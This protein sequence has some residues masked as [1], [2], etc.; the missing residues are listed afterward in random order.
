MKYVL[1]KAHDSHFTNNFVKHSTKTIISHNDLTSK[2]LKI[3]FSFEILQSFL[4]E[5]TT[6]HSI[7]S[8]IPNN[9]IVLNKKRSVI[10]LKFM[11]LLAELFIV[12]GFLKFC[13]IIC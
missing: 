11:Q 12:F 8:D 3:A 13:K 7:L 10:S 9:A 4:L 1:E 6:T 5:K 2:Y